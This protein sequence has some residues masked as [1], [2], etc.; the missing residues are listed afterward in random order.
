MRSK[1]F[2]SWQINVIECKMCCRNIW[3]WFTNLYRHTFKQFSSK[4]TIQIFLITICTCFLKF[5]GSL[6]ANMILGIIIL[7]KKYSFAKYLSVLTITIGII[8]CT[9]VSGM[10]VVS[11]YYSLCCNF[12]YEF[13]ANATFVLK[14][15][16]SLLECNYCV[17]HFDC[18]NNRPNRMWWLKIRLDSLCCSGGCAAFH[19]SYLD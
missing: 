10:N 5:Q 12:F 15:L 17:I 8:I 4:I 11:K 9:I 7:K 16:N 13:N 18:R 14:M 19:C 2:K 6:I 3:N 1:L